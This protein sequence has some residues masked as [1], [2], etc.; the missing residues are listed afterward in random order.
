MGRQDGSV[1]KV[2]CLMTVVQFLEPTWWKERT[3]SFTLS[4]EHK[5]TEK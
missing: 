1:G 2:I 3:D 5:H 4:S